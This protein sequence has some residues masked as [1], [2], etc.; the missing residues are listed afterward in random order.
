MSE[1]RNPAGWA[2]NAAWLRPQQQSCQQ[3]VGWLFLLLVTLLAALV[4]FYRLGH[5]SLWVDEVITWRMCRPDAGL[6]FWQ[7]ISDVFQG[8]L[9]LAVVWPLVRLGQSEFLLRL[10]AACAGTAAVPLLAWL[11][12]RLLGTPAARLAALLLAV[13]PFHLYYS[14]EA[15]GYSFLVLFAIASSLV[16]LHMLQRGPRLGS[17]MLY[18][19]LSICGVWS[20]MSS[21]FLWAGHGVSLLLLARPT[22]RRDWLLWL[23]AFA[24]V[25][26][27]ATPWL[28][29]AS[30]ILAV[31]RLVP[32]AETGEALRGETT[33][34]PM[35]YLWSAFA[36]FFG[37]SLG[38]S[39]RELHQAPLAAVRAFL[40]LLVPAGLVAMMAFLPGLFRLRRRQW[41]LVVWMVLPLLAVALLVLRNVK[42]LHPRYLSIAFPWVLLITAHGLLA[43]PRRPAV[44]LCGLLLGLFLWSVIGYDFNPRYAKADMRGAASLVAQNNTESER[45]LVPVA[46]PAFR[47]YY[48]GP[49]QIVGY[50]GSQDLTTEAQARAFFYDLLGDAQGCWLVLA[51]M[52]NLD[53]QDW[54]SRVLAQEGVILTDE[55]LAGVRV[56]RWRKAKAAGAEHEP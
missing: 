25:L 12:S 35:G 45:I 39:L 15:R 2:P 11:G 13:S 40:P 47:Y 26:L 14:Q 30:G 51:R 32:G 56:I 48:R 21:L 34:S 31:E 36:F 4:R 1:P 20:N 43:W 22:E 9:Y 50:F 46:V 37:Y 23:L 7:Q 3:H 24:G 28:L 8:P 44:G 33:A 29:K 10:P 16:F 5:Q 54:L 6:S 27:A 38:P 42:P 52:W 41:M 55:D 53:R 19:G 18:A 49:G 17:A